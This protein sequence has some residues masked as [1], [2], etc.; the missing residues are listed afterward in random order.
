MIIENI[1]IVKLKRIE[2]IH[3]RTDKHDARNVFG[4]LPVSSAPEELTCFRF[5]TES[6]ELT[7]K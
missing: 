2:A 4:Q 3:N 5:S 6:R 7:G 1:H